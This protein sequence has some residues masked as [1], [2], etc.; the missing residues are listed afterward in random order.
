MTAASREIILTVRCLTYNQAP[1]V[2]QCLDGIV[3]QRTDFGFVA[4]VHDDASTDGTAEIVAEYAARY[5]EII[6]PVLEKENL[7]SKHDGSLSKVILSHCTGKYVA[8]IEGDDYWTDPLKLQ[9]E[10]DFL[11]NNPEYGLVR[12]HFDRYYQKEGKIEKGIFPAMH[13]MTDTHQG[14]ILNPVFAG[15]CTWVFRMKYQRNRPAYDRTRY[16]GGDLALLLEI[17]RSSK[18]KCLE[19]NTAVYRI[20]GDSASHTESPQ[21]SLN[22]LIK[23]KNTRILFAKSQPLSFRVKLW[24]RI[25]RSYRDKYRKAGKYHEWFTMCVSDFV[26]LFIRRKDKVLDI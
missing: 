9:K 24:I 25:C 8:Y 11:E 2:R 13:G 16:F 5:P 23:L 19:E 14:Y 26:E 15:P 22:F 3:M 7:Y 10:V 4:L 21:R 20:L 18:V 17:S 6:H 1:F 12:T